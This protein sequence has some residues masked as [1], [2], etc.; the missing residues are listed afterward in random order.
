MRR[1]WPDAARRCFL[2]LG[3]LFSA[4]ALPVARASA[5]ADARAD[6]IGRRLDRCLSTLNAGAE[7]VPPYRRL[8]LEE[9]CPGL[10][11]S[12]AALPAAG[13]LSQPL[14]LQTTPDQLRDLRALLGSFR[15]PPAGV[16][17]FDLAA[18][19]ELLARTLEVEPKPP[20]SW[21]QRFK[22]W[23]AQK[24]RGSGESDYRWLTQ[25]LKSLDPPEWLA[26]LILRA[27]VAVIL[28][29]ALAV[30][31]N[32]LR[33]ANLSTWLQRRSRMQRAGRV[34]AA[35]GAAKLAW[36]DVTNL[37]PAQQPA[38]LLRLVL[39]ELI[40]RGLLPDD[41]SLTN[42]EM[43][44]RLGAAARAHAAAFAELAAA[45]DAVLFG[46]RLVVA[47]QLAPLHQAAHAIVGTPAAGAAPR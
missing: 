14:D 19:P 26:D 6:E 29:L 3:L 37:P 11:Q 42:R 43:L 34:P 17:R 28:L 39:Q 25:F 12:V 23:L 5:D 36:K 13:S 44:A 32:E 22:D 2:L 15:S 27:S 16:E 1:G 20:V 47:A 38:A 8:I 21:W 10:A 33:T 30:V 40:E 7:P 46:N 4:L 31:V 9:V 24:L 35:A 18:L 45:A 41:Q